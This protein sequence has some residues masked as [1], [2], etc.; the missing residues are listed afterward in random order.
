MP[1]RRRHDIMN[2][3]QALNDSNPVRLDPVTTEIDAPAP[4]LPPQP[5]PRRAQRKTKPKKDKPPTKII[6]TMPMRAAP[7]RSPMTTSSSHPEILATLKCALAMST[8]PHDG[9]SYDANAVR[10]GMDAVPPVQ[11]FVGPQYNPKTLSRRVSMGQQRGAQED[12]HQLPVPYPSTGNAST[13]LAAV[14]L[15]VTL[16]RTK[17][18]GSES[19]SDLGETQIHDEAKKMKLDLPSNNNSNFEVYDERFLEKLLAH[20]SEGHLS[21][22]DTFGSSF[23]LDTP[24]PDS[25]PD[26]DVSRQEKQKQK[27]VELDGWF[28]DSAP[29]GFGWND[30]VGL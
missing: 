3:S 17:R 18:K 27:E 8:F 25:E 10:R 30:I 14:P 12:F 21:E 26:D 2:N 15:P 6:G 7:P 20:N 22:P 19:F 11:Q 1:P 23:G 13:A 16:P 24:E 5:K 28:A 29:V 4:L 9:S